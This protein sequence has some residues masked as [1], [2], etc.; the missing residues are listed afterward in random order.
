MGQIY[1][2]NFKINFLPLLAITIT[3]K[4]LILTAFA[5]II[6]LFFPSFL[7]EKSQLKIV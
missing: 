5:A 1:E 2:G 7:V 4:L 3:Q 6:I